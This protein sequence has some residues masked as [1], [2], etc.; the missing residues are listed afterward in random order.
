MKITE[1]VTHNLTLEE[2]NYEISCS[3]TN[4]DHIRIETY[5]KDRKFV[6]DNLYCE[7]TLDKWEGVLKLMIKTIKIARKKLLN[8]PITNE[9]N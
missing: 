3:L 7:E 5:K 6:F 2:D 9:K 8:A 1:Q 4:N